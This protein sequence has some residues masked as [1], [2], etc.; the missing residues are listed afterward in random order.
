MDN[1]HNK[2]QYFK[3][4]T[5]EQTKEQ[6]KKQTKILNSLINKNKKKEEEQKIKELRQILFE[7]FKV[8]NPTIEGLLSNKNK[9]PQKKHLN[10]RCSSP[11]N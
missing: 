9:K 1:K 7:A 3:K 10:S 2:T 8:H 4:Q 11:T 6:S 5:K